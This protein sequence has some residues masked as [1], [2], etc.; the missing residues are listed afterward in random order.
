MTAIV[1][2]LVTKAEQINDAPTMR[3]QVMKTLLT[4][5]LSLSAGTKGPV[6]DKIN[7]LIFLIKNLSVV[8]SPGYNSVNYIGRVNV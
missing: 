2:K 1:D 6:E 8:R 3:P 4:P 7:T 5:N